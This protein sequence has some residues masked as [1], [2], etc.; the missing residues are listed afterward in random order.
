V[1][2]RYPNFVEVSLG[3]REYLHPK[4]QSLSE[5][6]SEFT[7]AGI[8]LFRDKHSYRFSLLDGELLLISGKDNKDTFFML[9]FGLPNEIVLKDLFLRFGTLKNAAEIQ[10]KELVTKGYKVTE[11]RDNFDYLYLREELA[12]LTGRK[13][14]KKKNLVNQFLQNNNCR[15]EPLLEEYKDDAIEILEQWREQHSDE[16]DYLAAK[17]AIEKMW[18]LQLCGGIYYINDKPVAYCLGEELARHRWFAIHFEKAVANSEYSGIYQFI[19]RSFASLLPEKYEMI[20]R[21]QDLGVLGLRQA[22]ESYN[23]AGFVRKYRCTL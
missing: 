21:E 6:I 10:A 20:N 15:V 19:N 13:F 12:N 22:K 1:I 17:E 7:F 23:P 9:P 16:G 4:F 14:H 11:D 18:P 2:E 8:Y 5:G 3:M